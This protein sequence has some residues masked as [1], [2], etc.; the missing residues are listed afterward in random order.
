MPLAFPGKL[1]ADARGDRLFVADSNHNRVVVTRLDGTLLYTVGA[2]PSGARDGAFDVAT[3]QRP[4]GL[5]LDGDALY[6]ADTSTTS[7]SA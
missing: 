6:V 5:A 1:L 2:G 3:F 7:S 4:Q